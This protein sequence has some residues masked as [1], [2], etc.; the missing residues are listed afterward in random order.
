MSASLDERPFLTGGG[1]VERCEGRSRLERGRL[2]GRSPAVA[3]HFVG[4]PSHHRATARRRRVGELYVVL[5]DGARELLVT[6]HRLVAEG[7]LRVRL[8]A[9][10]HRGE[11][12]G[13]S[14]ARV[15]GVHARRARRRRR[16]RRRRAPPA[17]AAAVADQPE[18]AARRHA[19]QEGEQQRHK[20]SRR[21]VGR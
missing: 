8:A 17:G 12:V 16:R 21:A 15:G 6:D 1:T 19:E 11:S 3:A 2:D 18:E 5:A 13:D 14:A 20:A 9:A 7:R 10:A 4:R